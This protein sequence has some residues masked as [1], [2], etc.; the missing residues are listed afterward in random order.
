MPVVQT[1]A[2]RLG[3]PGGSLQGCLMTRGQARACPGSRRQRWG[4]GQ[5]R[6]RFLPLGTSPGLV[7]FQYVSSR[8]SEAFEKDVWEVG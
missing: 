5:L 2:L 7:T 3:E 6:V 8:V 4:Q 1:G